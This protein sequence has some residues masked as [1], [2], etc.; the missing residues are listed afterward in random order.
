[1]LTGGALACESLESE[2]VTEA[3]PFTLVLELMAGL[4]LLM[5]PGLCLMAIMFVLGAGEGLPWLRGVSDTGLP[6]FLPGLTFGSTI[7]SS[8]SM[9]ILDLAPELELC[10]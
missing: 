4:V 10:I 7:P 2:A 1:M 9:T 3:V 5:G 8:F 6:D